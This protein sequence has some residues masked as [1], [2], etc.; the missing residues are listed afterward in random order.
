MNA[1]SIFP[2]E[3]TKLLMFRAEHIVMT[4]AYIQIDH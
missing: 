1:L 4:E 2:I 3:L